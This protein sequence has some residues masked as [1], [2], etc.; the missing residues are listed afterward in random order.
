MYKL[1]P[2][3]ESN[4]LNIIVLERDLTIGRG[5]S[6]DIV[7]RNQTVSTHHAKIYLENGKVFVEDSNS[8][9]GT[10]INKQKIQPNIQYELRDNQTVTFG[11][12]T[13]MV[14]HEQN[15]KNTEEMYLIGRD[16]KA[17]IYI[18]V[19]SVS[20]HHLKVIKEN[21]VWYIV[22][23]KSTNGTYL[24][25]FDTPI[26]KVKLEKNQTLYLATYKLNTNSIFELFDGNH[27]KQ[28]EIEKK[29]T[30]LG[31]NP[32][33]DISIDNL[34]VSW[35]HAKIV[36]DGSKYS[37]HDLNSTNG[38]YVNGT[39]VYGGAEIRK[40][41]VITLGVYEFIF[42]DN[43]QNNVSIMLT[44]PNGFKI[45]AEGITV[46]VN[47]GT[48]GEKTILSKINF[49]VF[50]GEVVGLMG[51]SGA[52][53]TTLLET[54]SGYSK[55]T[56]GKVFV[57]G[58]DLYKNFER[59]K[60]SIG[61]VP[62][63]DIIYPELTVYESLAYS[64]RLR[65]KEDLSQT[66]THR[67]I[68]AILSD[69]GILETMHT[70]IGSPEDKKLSGGQR[71]R[72]NIAMEL[73]AD[74][75]IIFLDEPTSG[76]SSVDAKIVMEILKK[77][78]EKGKTI[79]LTIHQPSLI[80]YKKMDDMIILTKGELAYFGPNYPDSIKFFHGVNASQE[81]LSDPDMA[82]LGLDQGEKENRNWRKEYENSATYEKFV[83]ERSSQKGNQATFD[84]K[85][86]P[87]MLSQLK[88]L[89]D[90]YFRIKIK[91]KVNTAILLLQAPIIAILLV[92]LF[93][94]GAG[95]TFH[96]EHPSILLFI[97][98]L[99]SMW[100]GIINSV[101]EIVSERAIYRRERLIG[102]KLIS[103]IFSKYIVLAF[104]SL[105]QVFMLIGIL[106][107]FTPPK[108]LEVEIIDLI[109]LVYITALVGL[110]IGLL[111][112][113][114]AKSISQALSL[115][116]II[117]L[118]MIIFGGGMIPIKDL[119][120][121]SIYLDAYRISFVMPT[122]W[123]LEEAIRIFDRG[124]QNQSLQDIRKK[125]ID[126]KNEPELLRGN[127]EETKKLQE[128]CNSHQEILNEP[129]ISKID[130]NNS[131]IDVGYCNPKYISFKDGQQ[132]PMENTTAQCE[133]R[134]CVEE[135]YIKK[136]KKDNQPDTW[137]FRTTPT[138]LIYII[139]GLFI[140]FP[141]GLILAILHYKGQK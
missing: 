78:S 107:L 98:V 131:I 45:D 102:L 88:T 50:P 35:E 124:E 83:R 66:E 133:D 13:Y 27:G 55:P 128:I 70:V 76:L 92:F 56:E 26:R 106:E 8:T 63:D 125:Q 109:V 19:E 113:A 34:N 16:P 136:I 139:L 30:L 141:L 23:E 37:I 6:N 91:D 33:A 7:I 62:Q 89:T 14:T 77:L 28:V 134:R 80:N 15:S 120:T 42:Q 44:K 86:S 100:F 59:I 111:V 72:V 101:K 49:T 40:G 99:S 51:L 138:S 116:P 11:E 127:C 4:S 112:S 105:I 41:D 32:N 1:Q 24:N 71:K 130:E 108:F 140:L 20:F 132:F 36:Y 135:L 122:R 48:P 12:A 85:N 9:N 67:R 39:R 73:L 95:N 21:G 61:F 68:H 137:I 31:R 81:I 65:L 104:L 79:L 103:Y 114:I 2:T 90:R 10:Y 110:S 121:N 74:P 47:I 54:L 94:S 46:K 38:T 69:L 129:I 75:E 119:P 60:N 52:G 96:E 115:V 64:L 84:T 29:E 22:D 18:N 3:G 17:D 43:K 57:N 82:L 53:K 97:L 118:P 5:E 126:C 58:I 25:N 123:S 93:S 117:L 87:S